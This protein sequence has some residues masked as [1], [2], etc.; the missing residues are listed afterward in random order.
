MDCTT[1][2]E[3]EADAVESQVRQVILSYKKIAV[4]ADQSDLPNAL[5]QVIAAFP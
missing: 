2:L 5:Q 4:Q 3:A 1:K